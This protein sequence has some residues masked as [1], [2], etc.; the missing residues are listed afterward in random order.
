MLGWALASIA[1]VAA[2]G[3]AVVLAT[4]DANQQAELW[5]ELGKGFIQVLAIGVLGT[6]LKLLVDHYQA[7]RDRRDQRQ[8][9]R[10]DKYDRLVDATNRLRKVPILINANRSVKTWSEQMLAV[11][12]AGLDLRMIKHQIASSRG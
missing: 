10:Q 1:A 8:Q 9:F 2:V 4:R 11:I 5:Q 3:F 6:A 7:Q 12:D